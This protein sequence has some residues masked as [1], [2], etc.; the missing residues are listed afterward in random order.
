MRNA[1]FIILISLFILI[2][3][4]TLA[5]NGLE[6]TPAVK[7]KTEQISNV[8]DRL[9]EKISLFFKFN[10]AD[11]LTYQQQLAELRLGELDYVIRTGQGDFIE[12]VSTRYAAYIGRLSESLLPS[13]NTSQ[14]E[15][16]LE[17]FKNHSPILAT[18]RDNFPA[19]SGF[20]LLLQHDINTVQ[21]Y[22]DK[23]EKSK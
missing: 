13:K 3:Q 14:K 2:P 7:I 6:S 1:I 18:M 17:M 22:S 10:N 11:K 23:I 19:N 16:A 9:K 15:Q 20:W 21:I 12:E 5:D 4:I 8:I